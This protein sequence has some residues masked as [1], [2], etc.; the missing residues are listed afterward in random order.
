MEQ[1][2]IADRHHRRSNQIP[3][4]IQDKT[5]VPQTAQLAAQDP[6][7]DTSRWGGYGNLWAPH[8]YM[9]AQNPDDPTGLSAF[10]RWMYGPWFWPPATPPHGP[11]ANPYYNPA[12]DPTHGFCEPELIPGTPNIS[13]GME[14]FNDTPIVNGTAYPTGDPRPEVLPLPHSERRQR[15]LLES[16]MVRGRCHG[17]RGCAERLR[18]GSRPDR[19]EHRSRRLT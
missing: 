14:A 13:V 2:L 3:L 1:K 5:F 19:P 17:N 15:P 9:P 16:A 12:C 7:W 10:G 11:I 6:T 4:V 18:G 8:V